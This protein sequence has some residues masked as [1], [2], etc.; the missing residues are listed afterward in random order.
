MSL[1]FKCPKCSHEELEIV[2]VS[3]VMSSKVVNIDEDG[4]FEYDLID[5]DGGCTDR[6]QCFKCGYVLKDKNDEAITIEEDI[7][8]WVKKN[9]KQGK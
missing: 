6:Y 3:A 9:C 5:C 8:E 1:K 2:E 4:Y 7:V